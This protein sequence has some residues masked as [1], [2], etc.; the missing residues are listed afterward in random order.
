VCLCVCVY[1]CLWTYPPFAGD[2]RPKCAHCSVRFA[3]SVLQQHQDNCD[4]TRQCRD[5]LK[6]GARRVWLAALC[7]IV[8]HPCVLNGLMTQHRRIPSRLLEDHKTKC[9]L[10]KVECPKCGT[11]GF[12]LQMTKHIS[13]C[14]KVGPRLAHTQLTQAPCPRFLIFT[15]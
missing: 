15:M 12:A 11:R 4:A 5:C 6:Y 14:T 3:A 9:A 8:L 2:P 10:R 13:T 1:G 7:A